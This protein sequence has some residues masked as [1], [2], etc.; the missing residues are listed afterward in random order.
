[1]KEDKAKDEKHC[2]EGTIGSNYTI[3]TPPQEFI[4]TI[5]NRTLVIIPPKLK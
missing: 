5:K 4:E 3:E 1:M 2:W